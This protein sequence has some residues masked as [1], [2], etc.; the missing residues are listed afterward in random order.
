[1]SGSMPAVRSALGIALAVLA[2]QATGATDGQDGL[3][4]CAVIAAPDSRLACYDALARRPASAAS[5]QT[6]VVASGAEVP[7]VASAAPAAAAVPGAAT[8]FGLTP[9]QVHE[10]PVAPEAIAA[11][12]D[13]ISEDRNRTVTIRLDNGQTWVLTE[14]DMRLRP[15]DRVTIKHGA[16]GSFLMTT[17]S[18]HS[19]HVKRIQ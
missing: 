8:G 7:P 18:R 4:R 16:L 3:A 13:S 5:T 6:P 14:G 17:P 1:M 10:K 9:A 12:V 2:A 19:Y 15:G 11:I